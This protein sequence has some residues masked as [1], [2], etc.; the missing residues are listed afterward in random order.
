VLA[1]LAVLT[2]LFAPAT[3]Q[4]PGGPS[5]SAGE[6]IGARLLAPAI[7]EGMKAESPRLGPSGLR[8][9]D[10]RAMEANYLA[11]AAAAAVL[12]LLRIFFV[13]GLRSATRQRL[14]GI[15]LVVPRGPP[16]LQAT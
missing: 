7:R 5:R 13:L 1:F 11:V 16:S 9:R 2:I 10:Q 4:G 15:R 14:L 6:P 12:L 3:D 8:V